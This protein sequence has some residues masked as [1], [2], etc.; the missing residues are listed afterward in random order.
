VTR[1]AVLGLGRMGVPIANRLES[2]GH[3]LS[4]WN[5]SP[6]AMVP[7]KERGVRTLARPTDA[8]DH[9][10]VCITML[11]DGAAVEAV[12]SGEEGLLSGATGADREPPDDAPGR[13]AIVDMSTI[14]AD[15]SAKVAAACDEFGVSFLRAPVSGNPSVVIAG[16]LGIIVSGP[17]GEF[18]RLGALLRDIGP[19]VF[20]VGAS[21]QA[22][23]V[24]LA[25]NLMIAGTA[26][27]MAEALVL[28]E[29][30][31]IDRASMLE[32]MGGSAVGSPFV[33]YKTDALVADDYSSTFTTS[34]MAKDLALA[35]AAA[36]EVG[37][38]LA[39]VE[40][41]QPL[42]EECIASGMGDLDFMALLPRLRREAGLQ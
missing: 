17:R 30:H 20:Y 5:R 14:A 23:I 35:R 7:F 27:L 31:G 36:D 3:E 1:V 24:K 34:G 13:R 28:G 8:W 22:R 10:E 25:L 16:N 33:K 26:Q 32:V 12:I 11:A 4:V 37:V 40:R 19:N 21:E 2:A 18:D 38:P 39:V 42:I 9:A 6:G 15:T 41:I 29:K